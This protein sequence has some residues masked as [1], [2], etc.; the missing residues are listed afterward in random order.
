MDFV[1]TIGLMTLDPTTLLYTFLFV[2]VIS[3]IAGIIVIMNKNEKMSTPANIQRIGNTQIPEMEKILASYYKPK[4][5]LASQKVPDNQKSLVNFAPLTVMQT[6]YVGPETDGVYNEEQSIAAALKAGSRCFVLHIDYHENSNLPKPAFPDA[7]EPCL[8]YRDQ[9]DVIRSLNAGSIQKVA[10]TLSNLAFNDIISLRKD[11]LI[12]ILYFVKTPTP[13]TKEYLRYCSKVAR[14][15]S[16]LS[17]FLL[18]QA[19]EGVYNRQGRQDDL[20]YTAIQNLERRVILMSNINTN[21][22]RDPK[23]VGV[24]SVPISEDL[25]FMVHLRLYGQ[26]DAL[27]GATER[28]DKNQLPRGFFERFTYYTTVPDKNIRDVVETNRIRWAVGLPLPGVI[29][30]LKDV[31][32]VTDKMG[33]QCVP[34]NIFKLKDTD[35]PVLNLWK[36][37]WKAKPQALRFTRPDPFRPLSPSPRLNANKGALSSPQL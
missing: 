20:L 18:G 25:D 11:P 9:G 37:G 33:V 26:T 7:F 27:Q 35:T 1:S 4:P 21:I 16:P 36:D 23:R 14:Q 3:A 6:G 24:Q 31:Q 5:S 19:P 22:F 2:F 13:D 28:A 34:L 30:E 15:L 12:V 10:Q 29:P 8:L 17:R 32:T